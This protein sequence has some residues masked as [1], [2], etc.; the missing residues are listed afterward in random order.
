M[1]PKFHVTKADTPRNSPFT[2]EENGFYKT[3]KKNIREIL[4]TLPANL[5]N[6]SKLYVDLLLVAYLATAI[7]A[8]KYVNY[9][10]GAV[11]GMTLCM[12][13]IAAHNFFHQKDSFR[14]YYF[15]MS[16]MSSR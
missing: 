15:D 3:L 2:F 11:S 12:L 10:I 5:K 16:L 9:Y 1:L 7:I 8:A 13:T 14:M 4:P 6:R